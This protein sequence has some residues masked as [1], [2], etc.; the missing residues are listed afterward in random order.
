[1]TTMTQPMTEPTPRV[2]IAIRR[3]APGAESDAAYA[4]PALLG[5]MI[6]E[7]VGGIG[8]ALADLVPAGARVLIKPNWVHHRNAAGAGMACMVTHP[9]FLLAALREVLAAR[10]REVILGDAPIQGCRWD[11]LVTE[12]FRRRVTE[13]ASAAGVAA[14]FVDF[15]RT[16]LTEGG[17]AADVRTAAREEGRYVLFDL[18]PDSLL[19]PV[20]SPPGR[21]RVTCY[22]PRILARRHA[23]GRHQYLVCREALEADVILSV[24]KLK[25]HRK[26]GLT[27]ALKTLVGLNGNKEFLPHHRVGGT[28]SGGDCYPGGSMMRRLGEWFYDRANMRIGRPSYRY[29]AMCGGAVQRFFC[30]PAD[31]DLEGSWHGNDTCW[32]TVLD[33]NRILLYG[34]PDGSMADSVQRRL[35]SLTDAIICG[36][37]EGP[38]RPE[39][40]SVGAVTFSDSAAAADAVHAALM[41]FDHARLALVREAFGRFRWPLVPEGSP[42]PIALVKGRQLSIEQV[43]AELSVPARPPAGWAEYVERAAGP[44]AKQ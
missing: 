44:A 7:A 1:M 6:R 17:L 23:P 18:G 3:P 34:R 26:A 13:L 21:F 9:E 30:G 5:A 19:E 2:G 20:S 11:A 10:P 37:G 38:L 36:Q 43:A 41:G 31:G 12:D 25:T 24:P 22:D 29:W 16:M 14:G 33:L 35:Y 40:L 39:P 4:Y 42:P 32:R 15:R 28:A 8:A 27:G